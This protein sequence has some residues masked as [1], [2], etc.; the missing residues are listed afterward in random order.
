MKE[1]V[2]RTDS[3]ALIYEFNKT[4]KSFQILIETYKEERLLRE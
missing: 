2:I 4:K 3:R 1:L